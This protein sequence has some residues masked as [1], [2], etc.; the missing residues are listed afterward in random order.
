M[1]FQDEIRQIQQ[2]RQE[3]MRQKADPGRRDRFFADAEP[4]IERT[5]DAIRNDIKLRAQE[6]KVQY[7]FYA[8]KLFSPE[9]KTTPHY[10]VRWSTW[11]L[12]DLS[13]DDF[14]WDQNERIL[15]ISEL[16]TLKYIL[17]E[18]GERLE[19]DGIYSVEYD[20][21][22]RQYTED[23]IREEAVKKPLCRPSIYA[24]LQETAQEYARGSGPA[25]NKTVIVSDFAYFL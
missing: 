20:V 9:K 1:R 2:E 24:E 14:L 16:D 13:H 11:C 23:I 4:F 10:S 19:K 12:L 15:K 21:K 3:T 25:I 5:C 7:N 18:I 6:G 17:Q 8:K 22:Y